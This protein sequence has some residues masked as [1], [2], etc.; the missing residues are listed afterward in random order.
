MS[1]WGSI[2]P[3][4]TLSLFPINIYPHTPPF[5]HCANRR[6]RLPL[7][8]RGTSVKNSP[9][10]GL[11]PSFCF[12]K[13]VFFKLKVRGSY[14]DPPKMQYLSAILA[15]W[16]CWALLGSSWGV[17]GA[18]LQPSWASYGPDGVPMRSSLGLFGAMFCHLELPWRPF[19]R[20]WNLIGAILGQLGVT[21]VPP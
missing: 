4:Y 15:S 20:P 9:F 2:S 13:S 19:E 3:I 21:G 18:G 14:R 5:Q 17:P 8:P 16:P 12:V 10:D 7:F 1:P 11:D 6:L